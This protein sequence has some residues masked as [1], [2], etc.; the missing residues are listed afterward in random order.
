MNVKVKKSSK[1][2]WDMFMRVDVINNYISEENVEY[3]HAFLKEG[4]NQINRKKGSF[5]IVENE[6]GHIFTWENI[7]IPIFN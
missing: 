7:F 5:D 1:K 6:I 3:R 4:L 2:E